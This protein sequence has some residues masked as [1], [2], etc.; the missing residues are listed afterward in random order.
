M[1]NTG[2]VETIATAQASGTNLASFTTAA[3]LLPSQAVHTIATDEWYIGKQLRIVAAGAV[4]NVVTSQPTYTFNVNFG[5]TTVFTTGAI[6]TSTTAHT[7]VPWWLE[8]LLTCRAV[9]TSANLMGQG[10]TMSRAWMDSGAN[11]DIT[12]TGHPTLMVPETTPAVGSNF[13][14]N[15][16]Q[17]VDLLVACS[18]SNASNAI[19]LHQY[20]LMSMN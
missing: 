1:S 10:W 6:L 9:G 2:W 17:S 8:I 5:A 12:T 13:S 11:A 4:S 19:Q 15:A 14:S 16:S 3:S 18:A 7:T 20:S